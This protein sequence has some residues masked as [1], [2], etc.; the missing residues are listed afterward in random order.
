[1]LSE[2]KLALVCM[3][4]ITNMRKTDIQGTDSSVDKCIAV[5]EAGISAKLN[6][7]FT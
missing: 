5:N 2:I 1:M 4:V 6:T 3:L 7:L